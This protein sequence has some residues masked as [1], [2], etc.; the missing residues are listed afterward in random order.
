[1]WSFRRFRSL[2]VRMLSTLNWWAVE[3]APETISA[4]GSKVVTSQTFC[5][6]EAAATNCWLVGRCELAIRWWRQGHT[7]GRECFSHWRSSSRHSHRRRRHRHLLVRL[8]LGVA[9]GKCQSRC[10]P[11][12]P[13][14]GCTC[15]L[16]DANEIEP[17]LQPWVSFGTSRGIGH[18]WAVNS[19]TDTLI[20]GNV[21][22]DPAPEF[23]IEIKDGRRLASAYTADDFDGA[24]FF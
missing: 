1:M 24:T 20:R 16:I 8:G 7:L 4:T 15:P 18:L 9:T 12:V 23:E 10:H 2:W 17:G 11:R 14:G 5:P 3:T 22:D 19:G 21:D 6:A 13:E